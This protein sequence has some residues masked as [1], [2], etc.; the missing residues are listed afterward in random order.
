MA[1]GF[2]P[3]ATFEG[4]I[5]AEL[6]RFED[7]GMLRVLDLL[8]VRRDES[9][10]LETR[11]GIPGRP[12]LVSQ[13]DVDEVAGSL[14]PGQAAGL[15]L[16]EHVWQGELEEAIA[17][18]RRGDPPAGPA[19]RRADPGAGE[20][21]MSVTSEVPQIGRNWWLFLIVGVV[22]ILAG[23]LAIVYPDI[24]LLALGLFVGIGLL[25]VGGLEIAEAIGG[26][27]DSRAL[28]AIVGVLSIIAGVDLPAPAGGEPA[29]AGDRARRL[30]DRGRHR[31]L[32]PLVP[33]LEDRAAQMGLGII[34]AI[35]G[36]LIL[37]LPEL[38]L[39]TLAV[40]FA[41]S[42]LVRGALHGVGRVQAAR[43]AT[44]VRPRQAVVPA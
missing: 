4:R 6:Q 31:P 28:T 25:F 16:L 18:D 29:G 35:L 5:V 14:E 27:P 32:H 34:D 33:E 36:I 20:V 15:V 30:P 21:T 22:S 38:S 1:V 26:S 24:T 8:F 19:G 9:G 10:E 17:S 41:L 12:T 2:G 44:R 23:I 7:S 37:S 13:A 40:L 43:G 39:V 3:E 11:P 42:L